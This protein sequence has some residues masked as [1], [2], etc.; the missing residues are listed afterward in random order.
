[1]TLNHLNIIVL[2][3]SCL[4]NLM[5]KENSTSCYSWITDPTDIHSILNSH[6]KYKTVGMYVC[7]CIS[8]YV[9]IF[10]N[11][12]STLTLESNFR[13]VMFNSRQTVVRSN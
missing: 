8:V 13:K 12:H 5:I 1:M 7:V 2:N 9:C 3:V 11:Q 4:Q 10:V 6:S